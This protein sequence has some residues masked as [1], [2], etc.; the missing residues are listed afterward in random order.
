MDGFACIDGLLHCGFHLDLRGRSYKVFGNG[1][2][3]VLW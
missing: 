1:W 3:L 2:R